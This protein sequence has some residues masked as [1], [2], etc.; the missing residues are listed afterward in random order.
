MANVYSPESLGVKPPTGGFQQGGWYAGRQYWGGTL[1]EP[2]AIHP[3]SNQVGA[4]QA[5]SNEVVAQTNPANVPYIQQQ[6][7]QAAAK[8]T[9]P[10][11][12]I[13]PGTPS[14]TGQPAGTTGATSGLGTFTPTA[15]LNLPD[16]YKSLYEGSGI[17]NIEKQYSD[18][19]K[20]FI[21]AKGKVNDNPFLSEAT[22]VGRVAKL[23][24][25]FNER[26][27]NLKNDIATKK[28]DIETQINLQT[29]QFDINSQAA[30]QAL[31]QFNSLLSSGALDNASGEDIANITRSTGISSNMIQSAIASNKAKNVKTQL[32]QSTADS[33]EVTVSVVNADTGEVIKQT[34][35]GMIGNAQTG[36]KATEAEKLTYYKDTLRQDAS[37]GVT[38]EDIFRLYTGILLP[39]DILNLYNANSI[40]GS[41]KQSYTELAKYGVKDPTKANDLSALLG[42]Q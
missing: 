27:A 23:E 7:Q 3:S 5:V 29:K 19:E 14:P 39:N 1:S 20:S 17:S 22:R 35:L 12:S 2:G 38:L 9:T 15:M 8:P 25:L 28:A 42:G 13:T 4:G 18:M 21:E 33:G 37:S 6:Q 24:T 26:T 31:N 41:A 10:V 30:T 36:A 16:L 11:A 34:S 40:Y 32:I